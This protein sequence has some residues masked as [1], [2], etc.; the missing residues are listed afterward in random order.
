M[1]HLYKQKKNQFKPK[2]KTIMK[3]TLTEDQIKMLE[4]WAQELPTKYGMSF[5]QFLAQQ[6]QEQNPKEEAE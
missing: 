2:K 4:A 5:I 3:I 1:C 6:V